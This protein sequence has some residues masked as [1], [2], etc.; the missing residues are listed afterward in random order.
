MPYVVDRD[1]TIRIY[2]FTVESIYCIYENYLAKASVFIIP[3][4]DLLAKDTP[5]L[6][7]VGR[8]IVHVDMWI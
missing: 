2:L 6:V 3:F 4:F 1:G 5:G 8:G 7:I